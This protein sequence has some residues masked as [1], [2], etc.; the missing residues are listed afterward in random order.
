[1]NEQIKELAL[2][3]G[4]G[5]LPYSEIELQ[6]FAEMIVRM[7]ADAADMA[8]EAD[9]KYPGDYVAESMGFG[10]EHGVTEWR[11]K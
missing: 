1:M 8:Y 10:E 9:C 11:L 2:T 7:C 5:S 3:A 6:M 4:C